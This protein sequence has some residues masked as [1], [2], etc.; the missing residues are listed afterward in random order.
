MSH[1]TCI[2]LFC[3]THQI[4]Q[5]HRRIKHCP[6]APFPPS[7]RRRRPNSAPLHSHSRTA[8]TTHCN[9][10]LRHTATQCGNH[11]DV[12]TPSPALRPTSR[13]PPST[14][15]P[16]CWCSEEHQRIHTAH[17]PPPLP[18]T[19]TPS[20]R[21]HTYTHGKWDGREVGGGRGKCGG[22]EVDG[23][24]TARDYG[25]VLARWGGVGDV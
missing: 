12:T 19:H 9:N 3:H 18:H 10:T 15:T 2:C 7:S 16:T 11:K 4:P 25:V 24:A 1:L 20:P 5:R 21:A 22:R 14:P 13:A 23:G 8:T 6:P 17:T